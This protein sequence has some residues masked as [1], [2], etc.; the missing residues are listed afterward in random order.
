LSGWDIQLHFQPARIRHDIALALRRRRAD[1]DDPD[2]P[3]APQQ[4]G[5]I[6][7]RVL[8]SIGIGRDIAVFLISHCNHP[9]AIDI[10]ISG[11]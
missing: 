11:I 4:P 3:L 6:R 7:K 10:G 1:R 2:R 9:H 5:E 8:E